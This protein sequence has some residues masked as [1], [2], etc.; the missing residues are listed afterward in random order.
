[1]G[2]YRKGRS[3][4]EQYIQIVIELGR[5]VWIPAT[6]GRSPEDEIQQSPA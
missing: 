5:V 2:V 3:K 4:G 6:S 1:M